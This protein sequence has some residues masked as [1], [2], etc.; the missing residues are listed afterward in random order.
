ML[1]KE[2]SPVVQD[3]AFPRNG[4]SEPGSANKASAHHLWLKEQFQNE[5]K[6]LMTGGKN[7]ASSCR[8][9]PCLSG[10]FCSMRL[11]VSHWLKF[12][13]SYYFCFL[14]IFGKRTFQSLTFS[15]RQE[16]QFQGT[17]AAAHSC[18]PC[19]P[20]QSASSCATPL[21]A[22]CAFGQH[23]FGEGENGRGKRSCVAY[24]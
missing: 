15:A 3:P 20:A 2:R 23:S 16:P 5:T 4:A 12:V 24:G 6:G 18:I 22:A 7:T 9:S 11:L 17:S 13:T 21:Q 10:L 8:S 14:P 1:P 19:A